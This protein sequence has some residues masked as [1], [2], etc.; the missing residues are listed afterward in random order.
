MV[1]YLQRKNKSLNDYE[2]YNPL[3]TREEVN[4]LKA[5]V[6]KT[7]KID[8]GKHEG[9]ITAINY[10]DEPYNYV[11][12]VIKESKQDIELK[13]GVPFSI[14]ENTALGKLLQA[15]GA[16]LEVDKEIEVEDFLK[17]GTKVEFLTM[18]EKTAKGTFARII[19]D[20]VKPIK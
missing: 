18:T 9:E 4:K 19:P 3:L 2:I 14:T 15:F 16:T 20:S 13:C 1:S 5:K 11:D 6:E 7:I 17:T 12:I 10:K 8:D